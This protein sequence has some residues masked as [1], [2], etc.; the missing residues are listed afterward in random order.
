MLDLL[1]PM[2]CPGCGA[3]S[4]DRLCETCQPPGLHRVPAPVA[5][6]TGA[7]ALAG[8]P[9][10]LGRALR[11]AKYR[12]DRDLLVTLADLLARRARPI[13]RTANLSAVIP[14]PSAWDR[15]IRR[16]FSPAAVLA[17]ALGR[18]LGVPVADVLATG[19]GIRQ[20]G[21]STRGR[22]GNL[23]GRIRC[24]TPLGGRIL[25]VDDVITTGATAAACAR[26][27]LGSGAEEVWLVT[28]CA[29]RG[30][31]TDVRHL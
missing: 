27:L 15:R 23:G 3:Y 22:L 1:W 14:A 7:Y 29:A 6:L 19:T 17:T 5:G 26:E 25:L 20:A 28:V 4:P 13:F 8:Y 16:G 31:P 2:L 30:T 18:T 24:E 11:Q 9:A 21:R 12:P 10:P